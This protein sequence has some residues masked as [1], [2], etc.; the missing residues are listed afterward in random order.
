M[1]LNSGFSRSA[2]LLGASGLSEGCTS[3]SALPAKLRR[4]PGASS[5]CASA[6]SIVSWSADANTSTGAPLAICASKVSEAAKLNSSRVPGC[7][8]SKAGASSLKAWVRLAAAETVR[9]AACAA[10]APS[11]SAAML[12]WRTT[13]EKIAAIVI[14]GPGVDAARGAGPP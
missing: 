13:F 4:L 11:A 8:A 9:S 6:L 7:W 5:F 10:R 3:T 14:K 12:A 2:K 1:R